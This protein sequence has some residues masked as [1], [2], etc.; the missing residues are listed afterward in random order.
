MD[1]RGVA[2][3][4]LVNT[5]LMDLV[6]CPVCDTLYRCA[7]IPQG[8]PGICKRSHHTVA[9]MALGHRPARGAAQA[10]RLAEHLKPWAMAEVF[11]VG[12]A[13]ALV[14][15]SGLATLSIGPS[16]WAFAGLVVITVLKDNYM[17]SLIIWKTLEARRIT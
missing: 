9:P 4:N 16:F 15:V 3:G 12:V 7:A 13:V 2:V 10:F 5:D 1:N 8:G 17:S 11:L 14:K 6:A